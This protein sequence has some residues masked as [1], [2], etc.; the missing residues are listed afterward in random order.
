MLQ[1]ENE[2]ILIPMRKFKLV[3]NIKGCVVELFRLSGN[4]KEVI[5]SQISF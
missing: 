3:E 1:Q 2:E 5:Q 4:I